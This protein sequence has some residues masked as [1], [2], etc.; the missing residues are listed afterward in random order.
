[1]DARTGLVLH[2]DHKKSDL[3]FEEA[4]KREKTR[5]EK[6]D[7]LFDKAFSEEQQRKSSLE[8]KFQEA[9]SSKDE[10]DEP[11]PRPWDLD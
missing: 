6:S 5:K 1:M 10:L 2:S 7:E 8:D 4:L 3:T 9:L 11:P